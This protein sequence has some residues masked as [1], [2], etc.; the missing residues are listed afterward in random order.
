VLL[1][2]N[3]KGI[4][5]SQNHEFKELTHRIHRKNKKVLFIF[6]ERIEFIKLVKSLSGT[7]LKNKISIVVLLDEHETN[8][9]FHN[10]VDGVVFKD[11]SNYTSKNALCILNEE[12]PSLVVTDNDQEP[13]RGAFV[14]T[15]RI[16]NIPI[17]ILRE[18]VMVSKPKFDQMFF[19]VFRKIGELPRLFAKYFFCFKSILVIKPSYFFNFYEVFKRFICHLSNPTA[20]EFA[21]FILTNTDEDARLLERLLSRPRFVHAVG[22]PRFDDIVNATLFERQKI[23]EEISR[24]FK[25][26]SYKKIILFLS[27]SQV[28]HGMWS[29]EK[30]KQVNTEILDLFSK[31]QNDAE[32][33]I[34][35]H[36]VEKNIFPL[37][38]KPN[39]NEFVHV[40]DFDVSKLIIGSDLVITWVSTAMVNAVLAMKPLVVI[41]FFNDG[42]TGGVLLSTQAIVDNGAALMAVNSHDLYDFTKLILNDNNFAKTLQSSQKLFHSTYLKRIDGKSIDRISKTIINIIG[43]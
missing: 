27:S 38:W 25:I 30:K 20:G 5:S 39:Y 13:I 31:F 26:P 18:M 11:L 7:L 3:S 34:K 6:P 43:R 35:L 16:L 42:V 29:V 33:I 14:I 12:K 36:P 23:R 15:A 2:S 22:D 37:I 40:T 21:D 19:L 28:E 9:L 32:I 41:D 24:S 10:E 8:V 1:D 17:L 4:V